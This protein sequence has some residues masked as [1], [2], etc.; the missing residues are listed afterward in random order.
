MGG[1]G[2]G[3][4]YL[5]D[6][7]RTAEAF[8]PDPFVPEG[9]ARLYKTGDLARYLPD[10]NLEFLGRLDFQVKLRGFRI[11]LGE[12]EAVLSQH[13][14]VRQAVVVVREE[15]PA[16][17]R[18]V[19]YV[20]LHKEQSATSEELKSQ[21]MQHLPAYMVPSAFVQLERLPLTANG[22][23]DR[24]GL[25]AAELSRSTAEDSYVAPTLLLHHQL[26]QIWEELLGVQP[27]GITDDF[28]EVGGDS[29][30]AVRLFERMAQVCGKKLPLST[31]FAG[32]TIEQLARA[33][34]AE[35]KTKTDSRAPLVAVQAGGSRRPFFYLHGEWRGGA[36]YSLELARYLGPDQPFYLLEPY[37]FESLAVPPTFEAIAAAHIESLRSVQPEGPYLLGG[38][39]NGGLLAYEMARQLH[40]Q[41][42]TVDLL[43]LM[44]PD[45]PARHR[46]VRSVI[47][48]FCNVMRIGQ[49]RQ[50]DW[51]LCLQH[52]YR[53][54][55]FSHYRRLK[56]S[57]LL[58]TV[59]QGEP[60][61]KRSKVDFAPLSL[62][63]KALVPKVETLRQDYPNIYDWLVS[64][65]TPSLYSGKITFFW[66]SE[67]PWRL[68]GWRKV[69]KAKEGEVK[70]HVIPGNHITS[71]TEHLPVLAESLRTCL[72]K[73]QTTA[74]S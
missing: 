63:L 32:A 60:W 25:P 64:D 11:E 10:G 37:K 65:Y 3:R 55:R 24:Q 47:S 36:L 1:I 23:L 34:Q 53:Y 30:L 50:F 27:I 33:L 18:L 54:L 42:Q 61:R 44:D 2:V 40:A 14:A 69:V 71:R 70:I 66:T 73:A 5:G 26:V 49:D 72:S 9:G 74:M 46:L 68:V 19:A 38:Y 56:N 29:L 57:E 35:T 45:S 39:C 13:S 15:V 17:K 12:I 58:G 7:E 62:R 21:V 41:G 8:V 6:E 28:F 67:E 51:F 4:G 16:D 20:V 52:I 31:L 43:V 48:H 22:K 59:E